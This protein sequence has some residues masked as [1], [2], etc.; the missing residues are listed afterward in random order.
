MH[1]F[2][3]MRMMSAAAEAEELR[4]RFALPPL[5]TLAYRL[6]TVGGCCAWDEPDRAA[7]MLLSDLQSVSQQIFTLWNHFQ[8]MLPHAVSHISAYEGARWEKGARARWANFVFRERYQ[9]EDRW[10]VGHANIAEQHSRTVSQLRSSGLTR[11]VQ[12]GPGSIR[13]CT[14]TLQPA[15]QVLLFEEQYRSRVIIPDPHVDAP[16]MLLHGEDKITFIEEHFD[17]HK[18]KRTRGTSSEGPQNN[19]NTIAI[20]AAAPAATATGAAAAAVQTRSVSAPEAVLR[21]PSP[22][23]TA[24][25]SAV[26]TVAST[27]QKVHEPALSIDAEESMRLAGP[28]SDSMGP[29]AAEGVPADM[30]E[31]VVGTEAVAEHALICSSSSDSIAPPLQVLPASPAAA[32]PPSD[33]VDFDAV[34]KRLAEASKA[35]VRAA[36][37][38]AAQAIASSASPSA[39]AV[40]LPPGVRPYEGKHLVVLVHGYQGNSWDM[41]LLKNHV[42][43]LYPHCQVLASTANEML[44]EGDIGDMG[45]RLAAELDTYIAQECRELGRL[46]FICHSLGGVITRSALGEPLLAPY[47]S[48]VHAYISLATPHCGY[49]LS[50][51]SMLSTGIW[52]LKKWNKSACLSQLSLTDAQDPNECFLVKLAKAPALSHFAHVYFV[53]AQADKSVQNHNNQRS[54]CGLLFASTTVADC[55]ICFFFALCLC[56]LLGTLPS[57]P[58]AW[59]FFPPPWSPIAKRAPCSIRWSLPCWVP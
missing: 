38:A 15:E 58:H 22:E 55:I 37:L 43:L 33:V 17:G 13:D 49:L 5:Y 44:T 6:R 8:Q 23:V 10:R 41:R 14:P 50:D 35:R 16:R 57:I 36:S 46:S 3:Q 24:V 47:L 53:A 2:E 30:K 9:I 26:P 20:H 4:A 51:N 18:D 29:E 21:D 12:S 31:S 11:L 32:K 27:A 25:S 59:R 1:S 42:L 40:S 54:L 48:K 45:K 56:V 39:A 7:A 52:F 34:G 28:L 19:D